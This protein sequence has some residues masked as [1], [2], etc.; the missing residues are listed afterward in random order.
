MDLDVDNLWKQC[1]E[2]V[3][4]YATE[5]IEMQKPQSSSGWKDQEYNE[6]VCV[7]D[8]LYRRSIQI[9]TRATK[10]AYRS[11]RRELVKMAKREKRRFE[12]QQFEEL[13]FMEGGVFQ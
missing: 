9:K 1:I 12:K 8:K 2:V 3:R 13:E 11:K 10:E 4:I 6:A 7:K 5:V